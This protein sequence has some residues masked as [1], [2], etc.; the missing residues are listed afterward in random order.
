MRHKDNIK[1]IPCQP[2]WR[3]RSRRFPNGDP[4]LAVLEGWHSIGT[5]HS[6]QTVPST[7]PQEQMRRGFLKL[8]NALCGSTLHSTNRGP[9]F[10]APTSLKTSSIT[11]SRPRLP[12]TCLV[13]SCDK[14]QLDLKTFLGNFRRLSSAT[15]QQA[16]QK[17]AQHI[18]HAQRFQVSVG[19]LTRQKQ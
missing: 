8:K 1:T 7:A 12:F 17:Q 13:P 10:G 16:I 14:T 15:Q 4:H 5:R 19:P 3:S 2:R 9:P 18:E 11:V 6:T